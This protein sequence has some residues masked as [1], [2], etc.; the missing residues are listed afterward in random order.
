MARRKVPSWGHRVI[1]GKAGDPD[2]AGP[3]PL[4]AGPGTVPFKRKKQSTLMRES[5]CERQLP[6]P[7]K[8]GESAWLFA[9]DLRQ[10]LY[11]IDKDVCLAT[12]FVCSTG[13]LT[14]HCRH[15]SN[16]DALALNSSYKG[17]K[18]AVA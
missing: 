13:W 10:Q 5:Q 2:H 7:R 18:V 1:G 9:A 12:E 11:Q 4:P 14:C 17:A 6:R 16:A 8:N 3:K 15:D